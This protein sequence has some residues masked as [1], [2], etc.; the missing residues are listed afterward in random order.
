MGEVRKGGRG[1]FE[2]SGKV[3]A[4]TG[5]SNGIGAA[6]VRRLAEA[7]ATVAV[8]Y[9]QGRERA[10]ALV[11]KLPGGS[12]RALA[13]P[14]ESSPALRAA[15]DA[16]R[17]AYGRCDVLVNSGGTTRP[18]PHGDLEA[19]DDET[20]DRILTTNVRGTF[21]AIRAFLPLLRASGDG[22]VVNISS[23]SAQTGKGSS[24]A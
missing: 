6:T 2:L 21:A 18:V 17:E 16:V 23:L 14:I 20:F 5:G 8:G 22:V 9:N 19:L 24:V 12:H 11:R 13:M 3:A 7:G 10:E 4:V 1:T 15:A